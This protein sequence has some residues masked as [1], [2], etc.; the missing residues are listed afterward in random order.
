[1]PQYCTVC[2]ITVNKKAECLF[3]KDTKRTQ[4]GWVPKKRTLK[5]CKK[6]K[7]LLLVIILHKKDQEHFGTEETARGP[8]E[9]LFRQLDFKPLVFGTFAEMSSNVKAVIEMAVEYGV[10]HLGRTMAATTV[11]AVRTALRRRYRTQLSMAVWRG[12]ANLILD[13]IKYVGSGRVGPNKAQVRAEMLERADGGE[14]GGMWMAH[15]TDVPLRD[16]FPGGWEDAG[17]TL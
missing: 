9:S 15:E 8:L 11:D 2:E 17:G 4:K 16:A 6:Y 10:E 13:R 5:G 12:Y 3:K 14:F 7:S 1:M